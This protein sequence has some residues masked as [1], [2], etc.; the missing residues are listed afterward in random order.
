M[1]NKASDDFIFEQG[2]ELGIKHGVAQGIE[3]GK[4][5]RDIEVI[6]SMLNKNLD[7]ELISEVTG[8]ATD[9]ILE[10]KKKN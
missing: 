5:E 9:K 10:I 3:K 6:L 1:D 4:K 2:K 7:V 8:A